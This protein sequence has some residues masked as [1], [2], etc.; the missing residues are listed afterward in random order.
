MLINFAFLFLLALKGVDRELRI[1]WRD[2][3]FV[4]LRVIF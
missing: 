3:P 1:G 2:A 4:S